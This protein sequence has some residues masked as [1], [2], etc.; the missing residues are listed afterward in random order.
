[1]VD[2]VSINIHNDFL[3]LFPES[4][5]EYAQMKKLI[6]VNPRLKIVVACMIEEI[7]LGM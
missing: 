4:T 1:M 6:P 2:Y 7:G 3:E 5:N